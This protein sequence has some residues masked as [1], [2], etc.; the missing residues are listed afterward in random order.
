[1]KST[2]NI[3]FSTSPSTQPAKKHRK[4]AS[5][6]RKRRFL[7]GGTRR[8]F[9]GKE[10]DPETGLYYFGARY[11]DPR[12]SRWLSGDPALGEYVPEAPVSEEARKRNGNMPGMGGVFNY[13]NLHVY[14]Y[15]G[16]NPV[17]YTDPDGMD[18]Y[19]FTQEDI[20]VFDENTNYVTVRPNEM[21]EGA[22]DGAKLGDG[23]IIKVTYDSDFD[24]P[25]VD[26]AVATID[27]KDT[28]FII[29]LDSIISNDLVDSVKSIV[30]IF[31]TDGFLL[32]G[33]Y[34]TE[35]VENHHE[36]REWIGRIGKDQYKGD[37][38]RVR[39]MTLFDIN[40]VVSSIKK[41]LKE[42]E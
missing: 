30:N 21:Y 14:H 2:T 12:A 34:S 38:T 35:A 39:E 7:Y 28:A 42:R 15:A 33:V 17:K 16:N 6:I 13:V 19:N 3:T 31:I 11:L 27:A 18:F 1:M 23:T 9:A 36:L 20:T 32:S 4:T 40:P 37:Q 29:G 26:V 25:I 41:K 22:I 24:L 8:N 10:R 5:L